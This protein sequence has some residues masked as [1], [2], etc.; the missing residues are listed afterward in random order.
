[1][2]SN[3]LG[4]ARFPKNQRLSKFRLERLELRL[5]LNNLLRARIRYKGFLIL[6]G[7]SSRSSRKKQGADFLKN[8]GALLRVLFCCGYKLQ[9]C[10][11]AASLRR[12]S[13]SP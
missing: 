12:P 3:A 8:L 11:R 13:V 4:L 10:V 9:K 6:G 7:S 2:L 5:F 1:M